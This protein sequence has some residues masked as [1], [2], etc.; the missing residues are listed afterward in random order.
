MTH[1]RRVIWFCDTEEVAENPHWLSQLRDEIGLTTIMPESSICHTS[2]FA[3]TPEIAARGPFEDWRQ[4]E[5]RW[6]RAADGIYPPVAGIVGGF[7]DRPLR[8]LIDAAH[9]AGIEVWGHLG[10]WS[11]G[12]DVYPEW[13]M[14]DLDGFPLDVRYKAWGIGLCPSKSAVNEWVGD[15]LLDLLNRYAIDGFCVDHA[16]YPSP[17]N[18]HALYACGCGEC[19]AAAEELG[20]DFSALT[21][22]VRTARALLASLDGARVERALRTGWTG[23]ALL[24]ALG[25]DG[26]AIGRWL[27]CRAA[28]VTERMAAFRDLVRSVRPRSVFGSDVFAASIALPGGHDLVPWQAATDF[29]TGG[30]SAGGV[31]GWATGMPDAVT[32]WATRLAEAGNLDPALARKLC[33]RFFAADEPLLPS[34]ADELP[35]E[36]LYEREVERLVAL[37]TGAVPLYPPIS[38]DGDPRRIRALCAAVATSG[39][40]GALVSVDPERPECVRALGDGLAAVNC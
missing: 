21:E 13:A 28:L 36:R 22:A 33:Q 35:I 29:I 9:V 37:S 12:G 20:F 32:S 39:C 31:V 14:E 6:P 27:H 40:H 11:Y 8:R 1:R 10:L 17:A 30:S 24:D 18:V 38:A 4:R 7:D 16:R 19:H 25:L 15:G 23:F 3:A 2:G 34:V 26:D 5:D